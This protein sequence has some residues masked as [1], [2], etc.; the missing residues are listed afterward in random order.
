M[1]ASRRRVYYAHAMKLYGTEREKKEIAIIEKSL[2]N[3]E[4]INPPT[5]EGNP[6]KSI[7]GMD[8]CYRLIDGCSI[9][10][11]SRLLGVVTSGV[12][13]EVNYALRKKK[14]VYEIKNGV[15]VPHDSPLKYISR[16]QTNRIYVQIDK[17]D[18]LKRKI[19]EETM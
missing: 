8:F 5:Y 9:V 15:L 11:F 1:A 7:E 3:V 4:I 18:A 6:R 14:K 13:G 17:D 2:S 10:V 16:A 12:G 19:M